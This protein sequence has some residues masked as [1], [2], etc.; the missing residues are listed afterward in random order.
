MPKTHW[1]QMLPLALCVPLCHAEATV[2]AVGSA[3]CVDDSKPMVGVRVELMDSD[4]LGSQI[5][6]DLLGTGTVN[7]DGSFEVTGR[8]GDPF[9]GDPDVYVRFA[10]NDDAGVR[11]T[12]EIGITRS[13]STS[14]HDHD[15][16]RDGSTINFGKLVFGSNNGSGNRCAVFLAVRDAYAGY[17]NEA[18]R[19][20]PAGHVDIQYWSAIWAGTPWTNADTI[21]WPIGYPTGGAAHEF[22]HS[23]RHQADAA[24]YSPHFMDDVVK[25]RYGRDHHGCSMTSSQQQGELL[26]SVIAFNFNEGWAN[27]WAGRVHGCP[28]SSYVVMEYD[29]AIVPLY[30]DAAQKALGWNRAQMVDVLVAHP[31]QIHNFNEFA[32]FLPGGI[33]ALSSSLVQAQSRMAGALT[34]FVDDESPSLKASERAAAVR[35]EI[36]LLQAEVIRRKKLEPAIKATLASGLHQP[37]SR[38]DCDV[39]FQRLVH[40]PLNRGEMTVLQL[41]IAMLQRAL[42]P[43]WYA[44][45]QRQLFGGDIENW[46]SGVREGLQSSITKVMRQSLDESERALQRWRGQFGEAFV[47]YARI[48]QRARARLG[49]QGEKASGRASQAVGWLPVSTTADDL[50][51]R[52]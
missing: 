46:K 27:Y 36:A 35:R 34:T 32:S 14:E 21:H 10:F 28:G 33:G 51:K 9:G 44:M 6:D 13:V 2:R 11:M 45:A 40:A 22:G 19:P 3:F 50:P 29:E 41:R 26:D 47:E 37:C 43:Q 1:W 15:N 48:L 49:I 12:D 30:L 52:H 18:G 20:P 7:P 25:Y 42:A 17:L 8:G 24:N 39:L 31:Q 5:C 38:Q 4:C 23:I 16:T